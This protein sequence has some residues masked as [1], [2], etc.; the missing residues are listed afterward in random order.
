VDRRVIVVGGGISGLTAAYA[1]AS[2]A[3][4]DSIE[5]R[6]ASD[7]L[8]GKLRTSPFAGRAAVDEGADAFL[9]RVPHGVELATSVGLVD[10]LTSPATA[11]AAVWHR[12][13]HPIPDGLVLGVPTGLARLA[14][15]RLL[16]WRGKLRAGIEPLLPRT[17]DERDSLGLLIRSRFG[18]EVHERLVDAL[19]GSIYAA[20]TDR[21]SLAMVPQLAALAAGSR[22]LLIGA[23][24]QRATSA[25]Q[26]GP[27]FL[28]PIGGMEVMA[29]AVAGANRELGVS[30]LV[31]APVGEIAADGDRW[32]VDGDAADAVVLATSARETAALLA[33]VAPETAALLGEMDHAGVAIATLAVGDWPQ[34]LAGMSGY[35]V[36]KPDQRTVTAAS[37]G[38]QK[39]AHWADP[40]SAGSEVLRISLGRDGLPIDHLDDD[41]LIRRAVDEVGGHLDLDLQPSEARVSRWPAAFPQYRPHHLRWLDRVEATLPAGLFLCGASYRGVGIPACIAGATSTAGRVADLLGAS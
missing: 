33:R 31:G 34:R 41:E 36:P 12:R 2:R 29:T 20:D 8:G 14:R 9:A 32:R 28:A 1:L 38:S 37:F 39:W 17:D 19:V 18:D 40:R 3:G 13:L 25:P 6:E 21:T 35:L 30:I 10:A 5:V 23:R 15:S 22:S 26:V 16:T 11:T 7:R 27:V 24:R 4:A